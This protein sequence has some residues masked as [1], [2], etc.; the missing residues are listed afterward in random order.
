MIIENGREYFLS[1]IATGSNRHG[2]SLLLEDEG[3]DIHEIG[4][5][6][7]KDEA[8]SRHFDSV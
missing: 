5:L 1:K 3:N 6:G 7:K 4:K 2:S 8:S